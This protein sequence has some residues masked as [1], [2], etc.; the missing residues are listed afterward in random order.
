MIDS[1]L[2]KSEELIIVKNIDFVLIKWRH[3]LKWMVCSIVMN[4]LILAFIISKLEYRHWAKAYFSRAV[5][6]V[7]TIMPLDVH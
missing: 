7:F 6:D 4:T 1:I 3:T 5:Y 2:Y